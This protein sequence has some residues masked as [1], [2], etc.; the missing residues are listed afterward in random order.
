[1]DKI[2]KM[3]RNLIMW[4]HRGL[5]L[6]GKVVIINTFGISQ[7]IYTMQV[8]E[9]DDDDLKRIEGIIFKFLWNKK[10]IGNRAPDRIKRDIIKRGYEEGGLKVPDIRNFLRS[11]ESRHPIRILQK[12]V[13]EK[14]DYDFVYQQEYSRITENENV[15]RTAQLTLNRLTDEMR[16]VQVSQFNENHI[17]LIAA[18]DVVEYLERKKNIALLFVISKIFSGW[19][20]RNIFN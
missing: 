2:D 6:L 1:M 11:M 13:T 9:Y 20:L 4:L 19:V 8:C 16:K 14:I 5:T 18:V 7:L 10:W 17:N 15:T 3:E 12:Y